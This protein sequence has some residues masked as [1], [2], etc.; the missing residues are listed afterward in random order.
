MSWSLIIL[1]IFCLILSSKTEPTANADLCAWR[2][3]TPQLFH[4]YDFVDCPPA[5]YLS[6]DRTCGDRKPDRGDCSS[7]CQMRTNFFYG[8]EQPYL[9]PQCISNQTCVLEEKTTQ[10]YSWRASTNIEFNMESLNDG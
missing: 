5:H 6:K 10:I 9:T 7:F 8:Q 3:V 1:T 2:G 4:Q